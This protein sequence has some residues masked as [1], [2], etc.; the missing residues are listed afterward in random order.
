M[1]A[2]RGSMPGPSI[3]RFRALNR[4]AAPVAAIVAALATAPATADPA[5][6]AGLV[7][8]DVSLFVCVEHPSRL[9][10]EPVGRLALALIDGVAGYTNT[11]TSW[12][13]L[14]RDLGW[15]PAE[16]FDELLGE[17]V[18]FAAR[19]APLPEALPPPGKEGGA[20]RV[21]V[22]TGPIGPWLL[23]SDISKAAARRL[24]ERLRPMPRQIIAGTPLLS[25]EDGRFQLALV[26]QDARDGFVLL[27]AEA[28]R[29]EL[30]E[31]AVRDAAAPRDALSR[32]PAWPEVRAALTP[33]AHAIVFA[34]FPP[35]V[36]QPGSAGAASEK[37]WIGV[38]LQTEGE[39][40]KVRTISTGPGK[41]AMP[42][43][44]RSRSVPLTPWN[45]EAFE[46]VA[47]GAVFASVESNTSLTD[48]GW[49]PMFAPLAEKL[50]LGRT[51]PGIDLLTGRIATLVLPSESGVCDA[52]IALESTDAPALA[53]HAD[54]MMARLLA[55]AASGASQG[56]A[57]AGD[58]ARADADR[59]ATLAVPDASQFDFRGEQ[60]GAVRS[61]N[62]ARLLGDA[63]ASVFKTPPDLNWRYTD[64][65]DAAHPRFGWW[66]IALGESAGE[67]LSKAALTGAQPAIPIPWISMVSARP[68]MAVEL[69][70]KAGVPIARPLEPLAQVSRITWYTLLGPGE[71]FLGGGRVDLRP[72][73]E[74]SR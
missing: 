1:S 54:A 60:P 35:P 59:A 19:P 33:D 4:L 14:A 24:T 21:G 74:P 58:P 27:L 48:E 7:P 42:D 12:N 68:A 65:V 18:V 43:P 46:R 36:S 38:A 69:L 8:A 15:T 62:A 71:R 70:T 72:P 44:R 23:A 20:V 63:L 9:R 49:S 50:G 51:V 66:T 10:H 32:D 40:I 53:P 11:F 57:A 30:L 17:R 26:P 31:A 13:T 56:G 41:G 52:A 39:S 5:D 64:A 73:P 28:S 67:S 22:N 61:I 45:A 3:P 29:A 6:A 16:A 55:L 25:I 2:V 34:R 47:A 37:G